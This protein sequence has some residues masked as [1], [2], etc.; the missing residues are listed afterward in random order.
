MRYPSEPH[1]VIGGV[2]VH[3]GAVSL[4]ADLQASGHTVTLDADGGGLT[5]EG[6]E[7]LHEHTAYLLDAFEE[8][9]VI[10]LTAGGPTIH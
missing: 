2:P 5:V 1:T 3:V 7:D 4:L 9:L 6:V 10:L 8:D